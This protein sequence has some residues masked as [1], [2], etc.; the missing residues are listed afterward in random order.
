MLSKLTS[1]MTY[2]NVAS[3]TALVLAIGGGGAAVAA[4]MVPANSVGS[5]QIV[6]NSVKSVDLKNDGVTGTDVNE[7]TLGQVPS[8]ASAGGL[9]AGA[10]SNPDSFAAGKLG[11]VRAYAWNNSAAAD[12]TLTNNGYTY[13]RS[14]G[15][16]TVVHNSAGNYTITFD[17]LNLGGGNVVVSGYGGGA[18]WCKVSSWGSSSIGV[19]CF[20]SAGAATDSLWTIAVSE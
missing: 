14:G 15:E 13:N 5:K 17:G 8:A 9:T 12:A 6:N 19:L 11:V 7:S 10:I 3:T 16:V 1:R 4:A 20:N 2:A 18:N